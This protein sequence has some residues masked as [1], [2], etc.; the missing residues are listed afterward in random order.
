[1]VYGVEVVYCVW[2][3]CVECDVF[4]CVFVLECIVLCECV[5]IDDFVGVVEFFGL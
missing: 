4:L 3:N 2:V 1:M 5:W